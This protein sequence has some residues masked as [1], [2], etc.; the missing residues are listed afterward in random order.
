MK[1]T[2]SG[3]AGGKMSLTGHL[4]ELR[5]RLVVCVAV[6]VI[7]MLVCLSQAPALVTMLTALGSRY[8]YEFVYLAPQ[9]LLTVYFGIALLGAVVLSAPV[10]AY[11]AYA[12]CSPGLTRQE[13]LFFTLALTFGAAAFSIGVCFAYFITTPFIL[14]F[15]ISLR[16]EVEIAAAI[17]VEQYVN[18]LL[19]LFLIFGVIFELPVISVLLTRIG[20]LKPEWLVKS[21]R[22]M[23]VVI[24]LVAAIITPPDVA[25]QV[26]VAVPMLGLFE[27][28]VLLSRLCYR[29]RRKEEK[30]TG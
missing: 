7:S 6:L 9:E 18:F 30:A 10:L 25:S 19:T 20:L 27:L 24:F 13:R 21:R 14:Y 1:K 2:D 23:I 15:L 28:S 16:S 3:A 26:L 22:V 29:L 8:Q 11:H 17:S 5:R 12:F 4:S